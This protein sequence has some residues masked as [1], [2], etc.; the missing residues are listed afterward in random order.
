M[1]QRH[2]EK[3]RLDFNKPFLMEKYSL[4]YMCHMFININNVQLYFITKNVT[5]LISHLELTVFF[6]YSL[7]QPK[8]SK[9]DE[10]ISNKYRKNKEI[11]PMIETKKFFQFTIFFLWAT[12]VI[13]ISCDGYFKESKVRYLH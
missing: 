9:K 4:D 12:V 6:L 3:G 1:V 8:F 11:R 10:K 5:N 2:S 13:S 7:K